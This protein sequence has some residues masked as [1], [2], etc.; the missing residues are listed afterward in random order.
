MESIRIPADALIVV[1]DGRKALFLRNRGTA[2]DPRLETED[3]LAQDNP[4]TR[5]QGTDAPGRRMGGFGGRSS[6][7]EE[8]DWHDLGEERFAASVAEALN[9]GALNQRYRELIVVAP[10]AT[11]GVL[12]KTMSE[13]VGARI[14]AEIPKTLTGHEV[15][16]IQRLLTGSR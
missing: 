15:P 2:V 13:H 16:E 7:L 8:T 9:R 6:A 5:E 4:P 11:L 1:G 3:V 10:P 12:R 14:I